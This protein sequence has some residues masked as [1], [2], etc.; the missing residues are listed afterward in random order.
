MFSRRAILLLLTLLAGVADGFAVSSRTA[1]PLRLSPD[2][3]HLQDASGQPYLVVGDTAWSLIAQLD[4]NDVSLYLEDRQKR[5]FNAIIVNLLEHKFATKAP[6]T[7]DGIAPFRKPGDFTQP[8]PAYFDH[9]HAVIAEAGRHDFTVWLCP[10]YLGYN[11]EDEG[12]YAEIK[13]AGP[14]ALRSY[15]RFVGARFKDLENIVWMPGGD[16]GKPEPWNTAELIAGIREG[17]ATQIATAHGGQT[18]ATL[19][20]GDQPWIDFDNVYRYVKDLY[21]PLRVAYARQPR[22]PFVLLETYYEG[23]H[24]TPPEQVRRQAWWAM[25]SGACGQFFG[26]SPIW[27]LGGPGLP[28][29]QTK[30]GDSDWKKALDSVGSRDIARLGHFFRDQ[31]WFQLE[32][33]VTDSL[34][35]A[36]RGHEATFATAAVTKDRRRAVL[37]IPS[38]GTQPRALTLDLSRFAAPLSGTWINPANDEK[39]RALEAALPNRSGVALSTPGDNG[40]GTN[41]WTLVLSINP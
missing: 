40:S 18:D 22:R 11:G 20:F 27:H 24:K 5:G 8:N 35:T 29:L 21:Q 14:A 13:A 26:N 6:A 1:L 31:Q 38:D 25:L 33:D 39:P 41:D 30:P 10:A 28:N 36:G 2:K 37:Y 9:A 15:G 34:I 23:E 12:F 4:A 19:T 32:P 3:R 16:F 17:G 7:I